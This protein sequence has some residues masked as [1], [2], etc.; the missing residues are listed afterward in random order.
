MKPVNN[1]IQDKQATFLIHGLSETREVWARQV[2]HLRQFRPTH[3]YDIRGFGHSPVGDGNGTVGQL[4]DDL[5]QL[6][7]ACSH[8]TP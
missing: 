5:A 1:E 7:S 6:V 4:A 8:G 3:A 2:S